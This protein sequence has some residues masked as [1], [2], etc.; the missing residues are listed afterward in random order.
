MG[1]WNKYSFSIEAGRSLS[2]VYHVVHLPTA[3]RILE[4]R[5]LRASLVYDESQL[6]KSRICVTW[7]SA[8]SWANGSIY[9]NIE[10]A[11]NWADIIGN[12]RVYWVEE[13]TQYKPPAYRLLLTARNMDQSRHV[14][15]YDPAKDKGPLRLKNGEWY[16]NGDYTSEFM[17]E[18]DI[19]LTTCQGLRFISH[20]AMYCSRYGSSCKYKNDPD[21]RT[22][23]RLLA[24][25]LGLDIQSIDHCLISEKK[26]GTRVPHFN[27]EQGLNGIFRALAGTRSRFAG[28]IK[29][30]KSRKSILCGALALYGAGQDRRAKKLVSLLYSKDVFEKA[31]VEIVQEKWDITDYVL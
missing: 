11:F 2:T 6:N 24:L 29:K 7:L 5:C 23:S 15:A 9:G 18:D 10:F 21:V 19:P 13:M 17:L 4:D 3:L 26:D 28:G 20:H 12:R 30:R 27:A 8:N 1:E 31:L 22:A 16:Y 25:I 14:V